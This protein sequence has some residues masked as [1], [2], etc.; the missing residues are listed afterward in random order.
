MILPMRDNKQS[1]NFVLKCSQTDYA[2]G[3]I[4]F[5]KATVYVYGLTSR[6]VEYESRAPARATTPPNQTNDL[7]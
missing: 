6:S 7:R 2:N 1:H 3:G 5:A 4:S